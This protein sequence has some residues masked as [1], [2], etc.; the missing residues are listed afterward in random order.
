MDVDISRSPKLQNL[1]HLELE[2]CDEKT[3]NSIIQNCSSSL[4]FQKLKH[5]I[6]KDGCDPFLCGN[7]STSTKKLQSLYF[8]PYSLSSI[9]NCNF[10]NLELLW[11]TRP[12][13]L[14]TVCPKLRFLAVTYDGMFLNEDEGTLEVPPKDGFN[15]EVIVTF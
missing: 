6:I 3:T 2:C 14:P 10:S 13:N 7:Q 8:E 5:F 11:T 1:T 12:Q 15:L 9:K 4:E